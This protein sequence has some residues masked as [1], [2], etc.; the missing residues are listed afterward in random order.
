MQIAS[1]FPG[2]TPLDPK[3]TSMQQ[4]AQQFEAIL[5]TQ[6]LRSGRSEGGEGWMGA[7]E[8]QSSASIVEMAEEQLAAVLAAS[9]GLGLA[10]MTI[11]SVPAETASLQPNPQAVHPE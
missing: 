6:L 8:D 11:A 1:A 7:G 10:R 4:A 9:G 2:G 3:S 5:I